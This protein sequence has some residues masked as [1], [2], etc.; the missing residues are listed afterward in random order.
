MAAADVNGDKLTDIFVGGV[1]ENPGKLY[2]QT[3][4]RNLHPFCCL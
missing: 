2:L 3:C 4:H 1:K